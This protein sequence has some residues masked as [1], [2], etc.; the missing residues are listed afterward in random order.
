MGCYL[1]TDARLE[2]YEEDDSDYQFQLLMEKDM[3]ER[4]HETICAF[5]DSG[6]SWKVATACARNWATLFLDHQQYDDVDFLTKQFHLEEIDAYAVLGMDDA[7]ETEFN[8]L[9]DYNN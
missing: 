8:T 6:M 9:N 4:K 1:K 3:R 2:P 7:F 5:F